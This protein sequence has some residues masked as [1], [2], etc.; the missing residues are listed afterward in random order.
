MLQYLL[1]AKPKM[2]TMALKINLKRGPLATL[3]IVFVAK[4]EIA[5]LFWLCNTAAAFL[6]KWRRDFVHT[7]QSLGPSESWHH[8]SSSILCI[9]LCCKIKRFLV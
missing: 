5:V 2:G 9:S 3:L 6:A 8:P 1:G 7:I 4:K